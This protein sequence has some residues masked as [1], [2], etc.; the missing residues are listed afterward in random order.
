[1]LSWFGNSIP[2]VVSPFFIFIIS[3]THK[4]FSL[5][6]SFSHDRYQVVF[7]CSPARYLLNCFISFSFTLWATWTAKSIRSQA[8]FLLIS[9]WFDLLASIGWL[10]CD[11]SKNQITM[12]VIIIWIM[13]YRIIFNIWTFLILF[14]SDVTC[15]SFP[16]RGEFKV[17]FGKTISFFFIFL[18]LLFQGS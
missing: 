3:K 4:I 1:M 8:I 11:T 7:C 18:S 10:V 15:C 12:K 6:A 14:F 2:S 16:V 9:S 5:L 13:I 17:F